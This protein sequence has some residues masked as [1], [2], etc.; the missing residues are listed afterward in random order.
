[1]C[2]R[3]G[4]RIAGKTFPD[5]SDPRTLIINDGPLTGFNSANSSTQHLALNMASNYVTAHARRKQIQVQIQIS[6]LTK[7]G[8]PTLPVL[9]K[10]KAYGRF[11]RI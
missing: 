2:D 4:H 1:M 7:A 9:L 8:T 3:G 6:L 11:N 5:S 10:T